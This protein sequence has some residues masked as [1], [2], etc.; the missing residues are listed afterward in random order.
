MKRAISS[1]SFR[2]ALARRDWSR[3]GP[4]GIRVS[5]RRT[6]VSPKARKIELYICEDE[7]KDCD[8]QKGNEKT[9]YKKT[10]KNQPDDKPGSVTGTPQGNA[11]VCH[12]SA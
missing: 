10:K 7:A 9:E 5:P 4:W 8:N 12:L 2:N 11:A 3:C 6:H 1:P